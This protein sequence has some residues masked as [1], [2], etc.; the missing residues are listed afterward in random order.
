MVS[1]KAACGLQAKHKKI[2]LPFKWRKE[3]FVNT[4]DETSLSIGS[5]EVASR[6]LI[7]TDPGY[8]FGSWFMGALKPVRAGRWNAG[9]SMVDTGEWGGYVSKLTIW[10]ESAPEIG[11]LR[12]AKADF[13]VG[14]DSG[15]A[16]FFDAA[17]YRKRSSL[18]AAPAETWSNGKDV[19][20]DRCCEITLSRTQAGV[21]PYGAVT[22]SGFGDGSYY[23][24]YFTNETGE[25]L[26]AEIEFITE[27]ELAAYE[28]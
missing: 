1:G 15:Q 19:W 28:S 17:H 21:L 25:I 13:K 3:L 6:E 8:W 7:V 10:H 23:C 12:K 9:I 20:Y 2:L 5:F 4:F 26:R 14:A 24:Y 18:D 27:E 16:G 22:S 11:D